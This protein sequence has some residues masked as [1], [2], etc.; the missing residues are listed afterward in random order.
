MQTGQISQRPVLNIAAD[1]QVPLPVR[2]FFAG[3][4]NLAYDQF[5]AGELQVSPTTLIQE[6]SS[7]VLLLQGTSDP[8]VFA[9][10][11]MPLLEQALAQRPHDDHFTLLVPGASHYPKGDNR[12][13]CRWN[14][15]PSRFAG[16]VHSAIL[17]ESEAGI[18]PS[19]GTTI[20]QRR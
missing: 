10:Q 2:Q 18:M 8:N 1:Q 16:A 19:I 20:D 13:Q 12:E 15:R 4:F 17:A 11:D 9:N 7:P 14:H 5:W 3:A 6:Y